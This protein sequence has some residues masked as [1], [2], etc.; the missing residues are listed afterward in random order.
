MLGGDLIGA[1]VL[2]HHAEFSE[3]LNFA[4]PVCTEI[5]LICY[6]ADKPTSTLLDER[7]LL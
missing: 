2:I 5:N 1:G 4:S 6:T 7:I 3:I